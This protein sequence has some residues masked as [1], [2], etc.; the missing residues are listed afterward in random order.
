MPEEKTVTLLMPTLNEIDGLRAIM[1][2][3]DPKWCDQILVLDGGST[4]GTV[5]FAKDHGYD[6]VSQEHPGLINAYRQC[7]PYI[8]GDFVIT[9]SPDGNSVPKHIPEL[10]A[11]MKEGYD[12][13]IVSRYLPGAHSDD[14]TWVTALGNHMF[15]G[16]INTGFRGHYTDAMVMYRAYRTRLADEIGLLKDEPLSVER[17]FNHMISWEPLLSIRAAKQGYRLGEIPGNEP[18]RIGGV[19]KCRHFS[20]GT[21]YLAEMVQEFLRR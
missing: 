10:I 19:G 21:V 6:L 16:L 3:V 7:W 11:K 18:P 2:L 1:P 20:W 12:M 4:D 13:V 17:N 14:D 15:T 5:E 8:K 9:F